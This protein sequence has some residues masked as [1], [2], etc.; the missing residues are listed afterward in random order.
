MAM[1]LTE[2]ERI[3]IREK[4]PALVMM[5]RQFSYYAAD[6]ILRNSIAEANVEIDVLGLYLL[7]LA[8][9]QSKHHSTVYKEE[10]KRK[11]IDAWTTQSQV[12]AVAG[13]QHS[14]SVAGIIFTKFMKST[15]M[16]GR[17]LLQTLQ[18]RTEYYDDCAEMCRNSVEMKS[19]SPVEAACFAWKQMLLALARTLT[20]ATP[21]IDEKGLVTVGEKFMR[22]L[23]EV[24]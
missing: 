10:L 11:V 13:A 3:Q 15:G 21:V 23:A 4:A 6:T 20:T 2:I 22:D 1:K 16:G 12:T 5:H 24:L 19:C 17:F 9:K 8:L 7:D 18:K 14:R